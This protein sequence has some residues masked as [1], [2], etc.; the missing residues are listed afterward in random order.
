LLVDS[1]F[2]VVEKSNQAPFDS[3]WRSQVKSLKK[4]GLV[5]SISRA[6]E[7]VLQSAHHSEIMSAGTF[8]TLK[9]NLAKNMAYDT[10]G[11]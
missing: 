4:Q 7:I 1:D 9:N 5:V 10:P 3:L 6:V 8:G 2:I 11:L